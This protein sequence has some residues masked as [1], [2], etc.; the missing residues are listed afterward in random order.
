M[1]KGRKST[2]KIFETKE[3]MNRRVNIIDRVGGAIY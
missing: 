3:L 2:K 1:S